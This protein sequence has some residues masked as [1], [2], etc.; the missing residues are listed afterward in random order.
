MKLLTILSIFPLLLVSVVLGL[1]LPSNAVQLTGPCGTNWVLLTGQMNQT[2]ASYACC[3]I[4]G[5]LADLIASPDYSYLAGATNMTVWINSWNG[6]HYQ[7][8]PL[9]FYPGGAIAVPV[10]GANALQGALCDI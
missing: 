10:G 4:G 1:T 6:D 9:T 7:G 8:A 2:D 3:T 5:K